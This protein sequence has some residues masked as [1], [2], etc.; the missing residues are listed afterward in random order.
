[1]RLS[2]LVWFGSFLVL[3]V[4]GLRNRS[5]PRWV[6]AVSLIAFGLTTYSKVWREMRCDAPAGIV[7]FFVWTATVGLMCLHQILRARGRSSKAFLTACG[8]AT[9]LPVGG[10]RNFADKVPRW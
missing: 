4:Q 2:V 7:A 10:G 3:I 5:V 6:A 1:M 8:K 9:L